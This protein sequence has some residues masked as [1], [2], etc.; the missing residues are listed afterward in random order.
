MGQ[1]NRHVSLGQPSEVRSIYFW[2]MLFESKI[3]SHCFFYYFRGF[4]IFGKFS[5][6][7]PNTL[8]FQFCELINFLKQVSG[9]L[10][11]DEAC[12]KTTIEQ[13]RVR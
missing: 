9:M 11:N 12:Q 4:T 6:N 13:N 7:K 8:F 1:H 5:Y 3:D 2:V 10:M